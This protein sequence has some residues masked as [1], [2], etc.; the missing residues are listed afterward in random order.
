MNKERITIITGSLPP[1]VCGVGDYTHRLSEAS[2]FTADIYYST[3]WKI[4]SIRKHIRE[5]IRIG[6]ANINMQYPTQGYG[7]SIVPH[8]ICLYFSLFTRYNFSVTLHEFS[9]L[10]LKARTAAWIIVLTADKLIFT[11][12]FERDVASKTLNYIAR[13]SSV[14]KICSNIERPSQINAINDR[15]YDILY[16]G[17]IRPRKGIERF[18]SDI[19]ALSKPYN[20]ILMGQIPA[21]FE[22]YYILIEKECKRLNIDLILNRSA[23]DVLKYLN[24]TK[25]AYLPFPDGASERRGT[26]LAAF[27]SGTPVFTSV[28]KFTTSSL[29]AAVISMADKELARLIDD[30]NLLE[31]KQ[32][33]ALRFLDEEIPFSWDEVYD[34]YRQ[35][36]L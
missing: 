12:H 5:L 10:S 27:G 20:V 13:K 21:G 31:Y 36:L 2:G 15:N 6:N 34:K 35:F 30:V 25:L 17:H 14:I 8:L 28:G 23:G 22:S 26:L 3:D 4:V 19:A 7:W 16:F 9:Q 32:R 24:N 33:E 11:N 1:D 18:L 29:K